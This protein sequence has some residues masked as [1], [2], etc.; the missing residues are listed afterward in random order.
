MSRAVPIPGNESQRLRALRRLQ[1]DPRS[2]RSRLDRLAD[3]A[4]RA[5]DVPIALVSI[6]EST[7][8]WFQASLGVNFSSTPRDHAFCSYTI[9][10]EKPLVIEDTH[11]DERFVDHPL[12]VGEPYIRFYA[13]APLVTDDGWAIGTLCLID[14]RPQTLDAEGIARLTDLAAF[15][16]GEIEQ[17]YKDRQ[18]LELQALSG[19]GYWSYDL[20]SEH[21]RMDPQAARILGLDPAGRGYR[22]RDFLDRVHRDDLRSVLEAIAE[23]RYNREPQD[24]EFRVQPASGSFRAVHC[25][26]ALE[27]QGPRDVAIMLGSLQDV[28]ERRELETQLTTERWIG[29][30]V[31]EQLPNSLAVVDRQ[32]RIRRANRYLLTLIGRA[33]EE[34]NGEPLESLFFAGDYAALHRARNVAW[35]HGES[36][37]E[38]RVRDRHGAL[39]SKILTFRRV[40]TGLHG[41]GAPALIMTAVDATEQKVREEQLREDATHDELT[42]LLNRRSIHAELETGLRKAQDTGAPC[43]A[44]MVDIDAFKAINDEYGHSVGDDVLVTLAGT[45]SKTLRRRDR[46]GRWGGEEFLIVLPDTDGDSATAAAEHCRQAVESMDSGH[47]LAVTVSLGVAD[48]LRHATPEACVEAADEALY[49]AKEAGRNRVAG[50]GA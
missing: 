47:D 2:Q 20:D 38:A 6:V 14:T 46:V 12:V 24:L 31:L 35:E 44:I 33:A 48:G 4:A 30:I 37:G 9:H 28:T 8:Q 11:Q 16:I 41:T 3:H 22:L 25:T 13:G 21:M 34:V 40:A 43:S 23:A 32:G 42:G 39:I 36:Q 17:Q 18:L 5:F 45:L 27:T 49:R 7:Y 29:T 50:A 19:V 10:E 15:A 26:A 1:I